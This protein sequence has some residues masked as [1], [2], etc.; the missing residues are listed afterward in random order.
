VSIICFS[1]VWLM[2]LCIP[3]VSDI[4]TLSNFFPQSGVKL[5]ENRSVLPQTS[6]FA[7]VDEYTYGQK[8]M[9]SF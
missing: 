4:I 7:V 8:G 9:V 2:V 5:Q 3:D 1:S 6:V